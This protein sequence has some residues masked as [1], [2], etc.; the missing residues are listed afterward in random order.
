LET[1]PRPWYPLLDIPVW[2]GLAYFLKFHISL[3]LVMGPFQSFHTGDWVLGPRLVFDGYEAGI[4]MALKL[5]KEIRYKI[6]NLSGT[7]QCWPV[8]GF[9]EGSTQKWS[10]ESSSS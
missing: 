3:V 6:S 9:C 7:Y 5:V 8:L 1:D 2:K 4:Y 10:L